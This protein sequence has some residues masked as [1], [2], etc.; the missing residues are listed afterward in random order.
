MLEIEQKRH[1]PNV[2]DGSR[3]LEEIG[4]YC[5]TNVARI[6]LVVER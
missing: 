3:A 4:Q 1:D 5:R 2:R 6:D